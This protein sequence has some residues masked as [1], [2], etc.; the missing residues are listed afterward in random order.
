MPFLFNASSVFNS[1]CK[2]N[3]LVTKVNVSFH[4]TEFT[5]SFTYGMLIL[6]AFYILRL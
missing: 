1:E 3:F 5:N 6:M 2:I 4:F